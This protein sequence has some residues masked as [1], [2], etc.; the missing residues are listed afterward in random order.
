MTP[1]RWQRITD[2]FHAALARDEA[3]RGALLDQACSGDR[4]LRAEVMALLDAHREAGGWGD[5]PALTPPSQTTEAKGDESS[6][7][8]SEGVLRVG[9]GFAHYTVAEKLGAGGMGVVYRATD[10]RLERDVALKVLPAAALGDPAARERL[11]REAR[12]ASRLNHAHICTVHEVGEAKG[13]AYIAMEHVEG[14]TLSELLR[15][16][17]LPPAQVLRYAT[18]IADALSHA[19]GR[20]VVHRDLKPANVLVTADGRTKVLDFGLAKHMPEAASSA[21][22]R[23]DTSITLP[24]TIA[25]TL[26][27]MSPEHLRGGAADRRSDVW[28]FGVMLHEMLAGER[29]FAGK[30]PFEL[31]AAI[32]EGRA[33][34]LPESVPR[35][36]HAIVARCL[37]Q[38]PESRYPSGRDLLA[39]LETLEEQ[40]FASPRTSRAGRWAWWAAL[41]ALL[42]VLA[43]TD[44]G[45]VRTRVLG[46]Q[47]GARVRA[48]AVLPLDSLAIDPEQALLADGIHAALI[49]DLAKLGCFERVAVRRSV[50]PYR[51]SDKTMAQIAKELRV[52]ALMTGSVARVGDRVQLAAQLVDAGGERTL[53][54][55]RY[56]RPLRD[57]L[58]LQ[59]DILA[60]LTSEIRLQLSPRS[61]AS[62]ARAR[63][64]DPEAYALY[65]RG[66]AL[67]NQLTPQGIEA[68]LR[69][70]RQA[71]EKAPS[72]PMPHAGLAIG[73]SLIG[74]SSDPEAYG[75]ARTAAERAFE[76]DDSL[77]EVHEALA[78]ASL[79]SAWDWRAAE[80]SFRRAL[81]IDP[82]RPE[83]HAH[84]GWY[85]QLIG[86]KEEGVAEERRSAQLDP[87]NPVLSAWVGAMDWDL[88]LFEEAMIEARKALELNPSFP[89]GHYVL[90]G[91]HAQ[92]GRFDE[93]ITAHRKMAAV[94][95]DGKWVLA[96][97]YALAGRDAEARALAAELERATSLGK[98]PE[99]PSP[100]KTALGLALVHAE[101][102]EPDEAFR[103]LNRMI[104]LRDSWGPWL[105]VPGG[106]W[107]SLDRLR[108][109]PRFEQVLRRMN[110]PAVG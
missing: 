46:P 6:E 105:S 51:K 8:D 37:A 4:E 87:V 91:V 5:G 95:G 70:L 53:W 41:P 64:V 80:Q 13:L 85:L 90:G 83:A 65:L 104:D 57:V 49:T 9:E 61:R 96:L 107:R 36:L 73:Y 102:D 99:L 27:Y 100:S 21:F 2:V 45:G 94:S 40:R 109:D 71:T 47:A 42:A 39:A 56:E 69:Y 14:R 97:T 7:G 82:T 32:L 29:P 103:W 11:L 101:L 88:G 1:E 75:K 18:Q 33:T 59:N 15:Q 76:L 67:V 31:S 19:H 25:G 78:M 86:R 43:V 34:P 58:A 12:T 66:R 38:K 23:G 72:D 26:A 92:Q 79:Y 17:P 54:A 81:E 62:L 108:G 93:A 98:R 24:G 52:D 89:W 74:H 3:A 28:S 48:I 35:E 106:Q 50:V 68:G 10:G 77:A 55:G 44:I 84:Y 63:S 30:T 20:D 110:L 22:A 60:S 16:Q